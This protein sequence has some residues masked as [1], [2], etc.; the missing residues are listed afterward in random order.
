MGVHLPDV[1]G[2]G[3]SESCS[4]G[5]CAT[6]SPFVC[7]IA[8]LALECGGVE[9]LGVFRGRGLGQL[10]CKPFFPVVG[11]LLCL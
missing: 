5:D 2:H 11:L 9:L 7:Q 6:Q 3:G 8:G 1:S 10:T 4:R